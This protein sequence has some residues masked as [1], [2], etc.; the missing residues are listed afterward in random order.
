VTAEASDGRVQANV[1]R[2]HAPGFA[3]DVG[4]GIVIAGDRFTVT[5][6]VVSEIDFT[7]GIRVEA[8]AVG[9]VLRANVATR[10]RDDGI[11]VNNPATTVTANVA[12]DNTDLGIEAVAGVTDGGGNRARGN[13]NPAQCVGVVCT[14]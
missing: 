6:N 8:Q 4:G 5:G 12:N 2:R 9:T 13:G 1:V 3:E 7:D 11:D 10:N 14:P